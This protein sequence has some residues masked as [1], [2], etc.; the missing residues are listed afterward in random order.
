[1]SL[2]KRLAH[3]RESNRWTQE[4]LGA[5][6]GKSRSAVSLWE[7]DTRQPDIGV[8]TELA[9][10]FDVSTDYLLT[11]SESKSSKPSIDADWPEVV[12]VLRRSEKKPTKEERKAI[13]DIIRLVMMKEGK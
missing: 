2:G 7:S 4:E 3:L 6:F 5:K 9:Q 1:M 8:L 13:A 11:G 12:D 10:L